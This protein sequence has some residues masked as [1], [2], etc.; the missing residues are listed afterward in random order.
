MCY[1]SKNTSRKRRSECKVKTIS[2]MF[3]ASPP[4]WE[5]T[6]EKIV[7]SRNTTTR[8]IQGKALKGYSIYQ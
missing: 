3:N 4:V 7:K 6:Q 2:N 8:K 5:G 1:R